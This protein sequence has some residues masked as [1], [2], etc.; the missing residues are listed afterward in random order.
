MGGYN[1]K[2]KKR[3]MYLG[4][5]DIGIQPN[6][7]VNANNANFNKIN[8]MSINRDLTV[9][10]KNVINEINSIKKSVDNINKNF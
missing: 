8:N 5:D 6:A 1:S 3:G 9:S 10:G 4:A 7:N 2:T